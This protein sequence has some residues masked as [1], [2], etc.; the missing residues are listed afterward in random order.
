MSSNTSMRS[1]TVASDPQHPTAAVNTA[2]DD[3][4]PSNAMDLNLNYIEN[5][6][7]T[8]T[9]QRSILESIY[10][11]ESTTHVLTSSWRMKALVLLCML[12]LP[13][14]VVGL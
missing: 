10:T 14:T 2:H 12:S 4:F 11:T 6:T 8:S 3:L 7:S 1:T 13:G 9:R 5:T